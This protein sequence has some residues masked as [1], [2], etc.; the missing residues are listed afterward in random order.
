MFNECFTFCGEG[1]A[2]ILWTASIS[3]WYNAAV[4]RRGTAA[5]LVFTADLPIPADAFTAATL[6]EHLFSFKI[7]HPVVCTD[8]AL[9]L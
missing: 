2:H 9:E 5:D 8:A 3:P 1:I 6:G 4:F 7:L